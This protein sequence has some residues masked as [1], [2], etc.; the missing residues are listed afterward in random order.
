MAEVGVGE[1]EGYTVNIPLDPG[2]LD[3]D[4]G[5]YSAI[6][7]GHCPTVSPELIIVSAGFDSHHSDPLG[8]DGGVTA[9][10]GLPRMTAL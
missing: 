10:S 3:A 8:F 6:I 2:M 9:A 7:L 4:Y 1:G 5:T